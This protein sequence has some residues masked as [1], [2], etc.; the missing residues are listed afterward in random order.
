MTSTSLNCTGDPAGMFVGGEWM[1]AIACWLTVGGDPALAV[2]MPLFIYGAILIAFFIV[3][4]S[5]LIPS[6]VSIILAGVIFAAF[7]AS[8]VTIIGVT[9]LFVVAIG[10]LALT[11]RLGR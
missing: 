5:P 8:G 9:T 3:G 1:D 7:P 4:Q 6:V 10:G 11:W 2:V